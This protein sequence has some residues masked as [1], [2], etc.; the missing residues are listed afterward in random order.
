[1]GLKKHNNPLGQNIVSDKVGPDESPGME[2]NQSAELV[3]QVKRRADEGKND[4]GR[5]PLNTPLL[6]QKKVPRSPDATPY[7]EPNAPSEPVNDTPR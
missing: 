5:E 4:A 3:E 1:M 2:H 6:L 7:Q